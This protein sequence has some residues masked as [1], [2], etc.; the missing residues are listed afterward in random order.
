[1]TRASCRSPFRR[2]RALPHTAPAAS[3]SAPLASL[4]RRAAAD[5]AARMT[6]ASTWRG[7]RSAAQRASVQ[8]QDQVIRVRPDAQ[9]YLPDDVDHGAALCVDRRLPDRSRREEEL[10]VARLDV[11]LDGEHP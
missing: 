8:L 11:E 1:M 2:L 4:S 7:G 3:R 6:R 5:R 9:D 10:A